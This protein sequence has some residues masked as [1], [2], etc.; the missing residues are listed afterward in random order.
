MLYFAC[1]TMLE[2]LHMI[3]T[4]HLCMFSSVHMH[5]VVGTWVSPLPDFCWLGTVCVYICIYMSRMSPLL[6]LP[7]PDAAWWVCLT[8]VPTRWRNDLVM[9]PLASCFAVCMCVLL[10]THPEFQ[11]PSAVF[12]APSDFGANWM[13]EWGDDVPAGLLFGSYTQPSGE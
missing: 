9:C 2:S 11:S 8:L 7:L 4:I 12:L 1:I 13:K 10:H 5:Y 6:P 3:C